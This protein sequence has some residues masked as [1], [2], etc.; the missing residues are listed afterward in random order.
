MTQRDG[1][2]EAI[3]L[4]VAQNKR[5]ASSPRL[6][7]CQT[8]SNNKCPSEQGIDK[9][10]NN[11]SMERVKRKESSSVCCQS[12]VQGLARDKAATRRPNETVCRT[13]GE[14]VERDRNGI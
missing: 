11:P 5:T 14:R 12:I 13:Y 1:L 10:T 2:A 8:I 7:P 9:R 3:I 6:E 4:P